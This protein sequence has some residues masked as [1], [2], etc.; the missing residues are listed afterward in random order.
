M[1]KKLKSGKYKRLITVKIINLKRMYNYI[2][3]YPNKI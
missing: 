3:L 2:C 1:Y